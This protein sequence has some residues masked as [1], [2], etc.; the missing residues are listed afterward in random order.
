MRFG[1]NQFCRAD[2]SPR[3]QDIVHDA[4]RQF[5]HHRLVVHAATEPRKISSC[6]NRSIEQASKPIHLFVQ[7]HAGLSQRLSMGRQATGK[8]TIAGERWRCCTLRSKGPG[9]ADGTKLFWI[10]LDPAHHDRRIVVG[11]SVWAPSYLRTAPGGVKED[12]ELAALITRWIKVFVTVCRKLTV[13]ENRDR[14]PV[15][16]RI[17]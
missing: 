8:S 14:A 4:Q 6:H 7:C 13:G 9:L 16:P 5:I 17:Q 3:D 10:A 15:A 11:I 2:P 12:E 1:K